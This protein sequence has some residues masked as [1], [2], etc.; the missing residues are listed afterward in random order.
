MRLYKCD[1]CEK[2]DRQKNLKK[3]RGLWYCDEC[4]VELRKKHREN[5][6]KEAGIEEELKILNRKRGK[7]YRDRNKEYINGKRK[8]KYHKENPDAVSY[9][10]MISLEMSIPKIN[11]LK[12]KRILSNCY[13]TLQEKRFLY[14]SLLRK[15]LSPEES[16]ERIKELINKLADIREEIKLK[17]KTE[18]EGKLKQQRLIEELYAFA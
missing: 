11:G 8:E 7:E 16:S 18:E 1:I 9:N 3:V 4:Y 10:R 13:L 6:I 14:N 2:E 15:G 17:K 5:S 12:K